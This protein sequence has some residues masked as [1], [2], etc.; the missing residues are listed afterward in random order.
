MIGGQYD[1]IRSDRQFV[2]PVVRLHR[3]GYAATVVSCSNGSNHHYITVNF[4]ALEGPAWN[5]ISVHRPSRETS[6]L[7]TD[8]VGTSTRRLPQRSPY[9]E[10]GSLDV[11]LAGYLAIAASTAFGQVHR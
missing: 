7:I 11:E 3:R 1:R 9:M 5:G 6:P 8:R 10:E 2:V 4:V